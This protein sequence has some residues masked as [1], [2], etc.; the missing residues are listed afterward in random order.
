MKTKKN[1]QLNSKTKKLKMCAPLTD[2]S[3][4][5]FTK[6]SLLNIIES[7]NNFYKNNPI[8]FN[9]NSKKSELWKL[10]NE[11]MKDRCDNDYCWTNQNF[12]ESQSLK[13]KT[14]YFRPNMPKKWTSNKNEWLTTI[15]IEKVMNQYKYKY[16]D[17]YFIGAVPIDFDYKLSPGYC[18]IDELCN[19]NLKKLLNKGK[20]KIGIVFNL[21]KHD[22][23]GS[24][25]V[26]L[27]GDFIKNKIYYFDSYGYK[28]PK[29]INILM[30][31]L[32]EQG[33]LLGKDI[34]LYR[35]KLRHQYKYSECGTYCIYFIE[36]MLEGINFEEISHNVI[37][38]DEM[39]NNRD[40]YYLNLNN[41]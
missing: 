33:N 36:K 16:P 7:W 31:R 14:K 12:L 19:I 28:E 18:V 38:D 20:T 1:N 8:I 29:E 17:F 24:H 22:Q 34:E 26:S 6:K 15:D 39:Q 27:F 32:K 40:R 37:K 41:L 2:G 5:C 10:V 9:P 35:N 23:E 4:S 3:I 30:N 13:L 25:W 11:K 21:D